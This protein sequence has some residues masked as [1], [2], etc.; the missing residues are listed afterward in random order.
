MTPGWTRQGALNIGIARTRPAVPLSF[1][2][3]SQPIGPSHLLLDAALASVAFV[4]ASTGQ[5]WVLCPRDL[6]PYSS[7]SSHAAR[8]VRLRIGDTRC[9]Q[10][11][12][13][14]RS[15][16][17]PYGDPPLPKC[18][19]TGIAHC[20]RRAGADYVPLVLIMGCGWT[21]APM[22]AS[23]SALPSSCA[24]HAGYRAAVMVNSP[25]CDE[26]RTCVS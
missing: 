8:V 4:G 6:R 11:H 7:P 14:Q 22:L 1:R 18:R 15:R 3:Q 13:Q 2:R 24:T 19:G 10:R 20:R 12:E 16:L 9:Q 23:L 25:L 17:R 26:V 21:W 5:V